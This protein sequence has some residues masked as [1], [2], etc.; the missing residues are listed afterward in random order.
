MPR[1]SHT[2]N[3]WPSL[4]ITVC[5]CPSHCSVIGKRHHDQSKSYKRKPFNWSLLALAKVS[6]LSLCLRARWYVGRH[7][8]GEAAASST[9]RSTDSRKEETLSL[10]WAF[11]ISKLIPRDNLPP[12][13][14]HP[15]HSGHTHK[16]F[17]SK[18]RYLMARN[19][20]I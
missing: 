12:T 17:P 15:L 2:F 14:P 5:V 11:E 3:R 8:A 20:N 19:S 9:P 6:P 10:A 13:R 7:R 4:L 16:S 18:C 1:F